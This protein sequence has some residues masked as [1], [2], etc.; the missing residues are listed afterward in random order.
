MKK[1][2]IG[3]FAYDFPHGKTQTGILNLCLNKYKPDIVLGA[4]SV[5]LKFYHSKI[6][7]SPKDLSFAHTKS[8]CEL[9]NIK[10]HK[11]HHNT[12]EAE[13]LIRYY[14][15]D[16]GVILGARIIKKHIIESF[17]IGVINL[18]PGILPQNR[19]LDNIKWSILKDYP[20]GVTSHLIDH[21]IDMG[22]MLMQEEINIYKDDTLLDLHLRNQNLEQSLMI[23]SLG[24]I[25]ENRFEPKPLG[26][27]NYF[28]AVPPE[29]EE[30]LTD[31]FQEYKIKYGK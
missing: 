15:L 30:T 20:V 13:D 11:V 29:L 31:K 14:D 5:D 22:R 7:I 16:V 19:G 21:R 12:Q 9:F 6:R 28:K 1:L 25:S 4:P 26:E 23:K 3:V 17:K 27:G 10:Y 8:V 18:H 24:T 2:K